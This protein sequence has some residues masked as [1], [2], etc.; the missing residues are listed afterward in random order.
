MGSR[1]G[2]RIRFP[3][4]AGNY[5]LGCQTY[6]HCAAVSSQKP[7]PTSL[8]SLPPLASVCVLGGGVKELGGLLFAGPTLNI[9][10]LSSVSPERSS[11]YSRLLL[12]LPLDSPCAS[13]LHASGREVLMR[14]SGRRRKL[15]LSV[16]VP[17]GLLLHTCLHV[18]FKFFQM[19]KH[20]SHS[21]PVCG[22]FIEN[23][24]SVLRH[25]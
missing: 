20:V 18:M 24:R 6:S 13:D 7:E 15:K 10:Q 9:Q 21:E 17:I 23:L 5:T 2:T 4:I 22:C 14:I 25:F 19:Y 11:N 16:C 12:H 8:T 3:T 1:V